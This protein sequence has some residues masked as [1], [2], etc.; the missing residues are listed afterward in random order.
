M[1][2]NIFWDNDEK[3][4]LIRKMLDP[5]TWQ[6]YANAIEEVHQKLTE[7]D[8]TVDIVVDCTAIDAIPVGGL[9]SLLKSN[10]DYPPNAGNQYIVSSSNFIELFSHTLAKMASN[11]KNYFIYKPTMDAAYSEIRQLRTSKP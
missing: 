2:I 9:G 8:H 11:Y 4:I 10:R 5:W 1:P 3:T 7:V 6:D